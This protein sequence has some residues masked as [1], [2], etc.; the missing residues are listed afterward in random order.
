MYRITSFLLTGLDIRRSPQGSSFSVPTIRNFNIDLQII[1]SLFQRYMQ[2]TN[3]RSIAFI[4][5]RFR[6]LKHFLYY[7]LI[8]KLHCFSFKFLFSTTKDLSLSA[9]ERIITLKYPIY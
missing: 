4:F 8:K 6:T 1:L 5:K 2:L 7:N 9:L 3:K